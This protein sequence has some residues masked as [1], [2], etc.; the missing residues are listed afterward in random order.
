MR[1][2]TILEKRDIR[3]RGKGKLH[4]KEERAKFRYSK[5]KG[6]MKENV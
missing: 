3:R 1:N 4:G 6:G 5:K 2:T